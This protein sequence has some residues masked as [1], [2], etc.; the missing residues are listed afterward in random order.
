MPGKL[1]TFFLALLIW[2]YVLFATLSRSF[3]F[4]S[5]FSFLIGLDLL[6]IPGA[7]LSNF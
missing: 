7:I 5:F 2:I 3:D 6:E 1:V 4:E